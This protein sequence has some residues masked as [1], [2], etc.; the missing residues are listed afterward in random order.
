MS[1]PLVEAEIKWIEIEA[2]FDLRQKE[3]KG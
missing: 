1:A 2:P 3:R